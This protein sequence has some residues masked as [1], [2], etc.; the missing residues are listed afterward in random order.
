MYVDDLKWTN[1]Y[2]NEGNQE[3]IKYIIAEKNEINT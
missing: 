2:K 3:M 1:I